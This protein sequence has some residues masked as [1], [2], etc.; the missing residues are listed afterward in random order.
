MYGGTTDDEREDTGKE[1]I[2]NL[3]KKENRKSR[4]QTKAVKSFLCKNVYIICR[5]LLAF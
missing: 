4:R 3:M 2:G 1:G 5:I